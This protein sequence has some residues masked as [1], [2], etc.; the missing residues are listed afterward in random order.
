MVDKLGGCWF[1]VKEKYYILKPTNE[2]A[3]NYDCKLTDRLRDDLSDTHHVQ[4][5]D[6]S[7]A[8]L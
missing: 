1:I 6:Q 8:P 5:A 4:G 7:G 2:Q 3:E